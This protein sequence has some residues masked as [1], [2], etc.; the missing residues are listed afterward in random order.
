MDGVTRER[1]FGISNALD[2]SAVR[3]L[4]IALGVVLIAVPVLIVLL[5]ALKKLSPALRKDLWDRYWSWLLFIPMMFGPVLLGAAWV[6]AAVC[7][8]S[9]LCYREFARATGLFR[10]HMI[11]AIVV[12][13][14][15]AITAAAADHWYGFFVALTPLTIG[16]LAAMAI[17]ADHPKGYIQRVALGVLAFSLFGVCYGHLAYFANDAAYRP[18]LLWLIAAVELNDIFA[19]ICG[20][21]FG[22]RKLA[23]RTESEQ[24]SGRS[25]GGGGVHDGVRGAAGAFCFCTVDRD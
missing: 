10:F 24:D 22:H 4:V 6:F 17:I 5:T 18:L 21:S 25:S 1:L 7:A 9:L 14:I 3:F 11:S 20:K 15:L 2:N 13:G 19:Y 16:T 12:L 23:P 8:L